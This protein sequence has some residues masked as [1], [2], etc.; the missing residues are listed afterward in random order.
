[1]K[2]K[3]SAAALAVA[4]LFSA[5]VGAQAAQTKTYEPRPLE[6]LVAVTHVDPSARTVT[7]VGPKGNSRTVAVP[8]EAQN[9]DQVKPGQRYKVR[10]LE[11][12]AVSISKE[13]EPAAA[14]STVRI[15]PKGSRPGGTAT[16]ISSVS[17]VVDSIDAAQREVTL[18]NAQ[19]ETRTF[20][21]ADDVKLD[22][23]KPGDKITV[24]HTQALA[25]NMAPSPQPMVEP[26]WT[27]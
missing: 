12:V 14:G 18:R 5:E 21:V 23:V 25:I 24:A 27:P 15:A 13:G 26:H 7:I 10:F 8:P 6:G 3:L 11:E 20:K 2:A 1:M 9:F 16:K 19:G 4:L 22:A 17:A